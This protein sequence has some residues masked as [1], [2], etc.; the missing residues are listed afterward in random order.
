MKK[1]LTLLSTL[2]LVSMLASCG[3]ASGTN[4]GSQDDAPS[5][6]AETNA[7]KQETK[8]AN[9]SSAEGAA[10]LPADPDPSETAKQPGI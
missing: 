9:T 2:A 3:T 1:V 7:Q 6:K 4:F 10:D 8:E 5:G